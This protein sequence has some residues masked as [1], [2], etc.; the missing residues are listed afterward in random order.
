MNVSVMD[1]QEPHDKAP[2]AIDL[3]YPA[4]PNPSSQ[5]DKN[6]PNRPFEVT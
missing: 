4:F 3:I 1:L 2:M 5:D 6:D